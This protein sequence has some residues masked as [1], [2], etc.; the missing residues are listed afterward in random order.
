MSNNSE[1][2]IH[3]T[4]FNSQNHLHHHKQTNNSLYYEGEKKEEEVPEE[5]FD[6]KIRVKPL[7]A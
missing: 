3:H 5:L 2:G 1:D 4:D 7:I 6:I